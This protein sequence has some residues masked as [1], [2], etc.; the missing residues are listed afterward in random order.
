M[1]ISQEEFIRIIAD[2]ITSDDSGGVNPTKLARL[3]VEQE[4]IVQE[5][6]YI[7]TGG[8]GSGHK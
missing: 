2:K 4:V 5:I 1:K 8:A 3:L 7:T 6:E